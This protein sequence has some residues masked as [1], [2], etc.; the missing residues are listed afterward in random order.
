M[1]IVFDSIDDPYGLRQAGSVLGKAL[2]ERNLERLRNTRQIESEDRLNQRQV[3]LENRSQQRKIDDEQRQIA[4]QLSQNQKLAPYLGQLGHLM[5]LDQDEVQNLS[6][7]LNAGANI[8]IESF[9][10]NAATAKLQKQQIEATTAGRKRPSIF[11]ATM[12]K[13]A[14]NIVNNAAKVFQLGDDIKRLREL[15]PNFEGPAGYAHN[16]FGSKGAAE[17]NALGLTIMEPVLKIFNPVGALPQQKIQL[18]KD[19]FA[20]KA[21]DTMDQIEGKLNAAE[22]FQKMAQEKA[23]KISELVEEYGGFEEIPDSAWVKYQK[24]SEKE[25]DNIIKESRSNSSQSNSNVGSSVDKL[26][27][28]KGM[29]GAEYQDDKGN[30]YRSNGVKWEKVK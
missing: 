21:S 4:Q 1:P 6:Q 2:M 27:A 14:V 30:V 5:G 29:E 22:R 9:L 17:F 28:A 16:Y 3:D 24:D 15:A 12:Q 18:V 26:P 7:A 8:D 20:V 23:N 19:S 10:K 25:I 13:E 11:G